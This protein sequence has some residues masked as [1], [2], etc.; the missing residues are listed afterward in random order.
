MKITFIHHSCFV[1]EI[2]DQVLV[3]DYFDGDRIEG[4][5]FTGILPE[6]G[7]DQKLYFFASHSHKDHFD[8]NILKL[9]EQYPNIHFILSKDCKMTEKFMK[10]HGIPERAKECILYVTGETEYQLDAI[11][12]E[13]LRSNDAGV[14]FLVNVCG[15]NIYHAGDLNIWKFE[16]AGELINGKSEREYRFQIKKLADKHINAAF[17]VLDPR[18]GPY[19]NLGLS[20]FLRNVDAD[21]VFPMHMWQKY[22]ALTKYKKM[23]DNK[24]ILERIADIWEENQCFEI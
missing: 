24:L 4:Y 8:M 19:T 23:C 14:A 20:Y 6:F 3:F 7:R 16:G 13:T 11:K 1:V 15:K 18:L 10:R 17:V 9:V 21:L 22:E 5:H 2:E 12:V